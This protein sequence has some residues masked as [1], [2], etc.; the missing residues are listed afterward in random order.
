MPQTIVTLRTADIAIVGA[1]PA[2]AAAAIVAARAGLETV[3]VDRAKFP[4]DKCCGDGLTVGALRLLEQL[5][6]E[7]DT[8]PSWTAAHA[9]IVSSPSHRTVRFPL[10]V[11]RG[12]FA[13]IARREELDAALVE[14]AARRRRDRHRGHRCRRWSRRT[15]MR[16][17]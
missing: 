1:G 2:G 16:S 7:P 11:G 15:P 9:A 17:R 5:G 6:L 14:V 10:P 8:I 4:R 12:Q 3:V 13:A